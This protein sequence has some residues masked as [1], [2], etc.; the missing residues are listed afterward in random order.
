LNKPSSVQASFLM[1]ATKKYRESLPGSPAEEYLV[2]R[3]F[4]IQRL[5]PYG[6]GFVDDPLPG[7]AP[8]NGWLAIPY[9][10]YS[11]GGK[12]WSVIGMRFRCMADHNHKQV[13]GG[14][15]YMVNPGTSTHLYN[16]VAVL[17]NESEIILTEGELDAVASETMLDLGAVGVPGANTWN[18][19]F[20]RIFKG[21]QRVYVLEDGDPAGA[22]FGEAVAATLPNIRRIPMPEGMDVNEVLAHPSMGID[23]VLERM[24][25]NAGT[26]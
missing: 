13:H 9:M 7:H 25:K 26:R 20:A 12:G 19:T 23:E 24:G 14:G 1:E 16:T 21:Y 17:K 5:Q 3:G 11:P 4:D 10:R 18:S 22:A 15:K 8:F 6:L 2:S